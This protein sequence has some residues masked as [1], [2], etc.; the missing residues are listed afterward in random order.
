VTLASVVEAP[1]VRHA[2]PTCVAF[3]QVVTVGIAFGEQRIQPRHTVGVL[4]GEGGGRRL[5]A[6]SP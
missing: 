5:G 1:A 3:A 6:T 2:E 4:I